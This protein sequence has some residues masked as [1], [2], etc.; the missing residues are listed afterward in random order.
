RKNFSFLRDT[1]KKTVLGKS[2]LATDQTYFYTMITTII[3]NNLVADLDGD[4]LRAKLVKLGAILDGKTPPSKLRRTV[5]KFA[6]ES[7]K[8]TTDPLRRLERDSLFL[9]LLQSL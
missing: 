9:A 8:Q 5:K 3:R 7:R 6:E 1:Y 2:R 4:T